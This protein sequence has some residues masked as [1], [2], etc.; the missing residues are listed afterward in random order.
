MLGEGFHVH[1]CN[2]AALHGPAAALQTTLA[3]G[4]PVIRDDERRVNAH[5]HAETGTL[6]AGAGGIVERKHTRRKLFHA[7]AV[8]RAGIIL[9]EED[10]LPV[11]DADDDQTVGQ[12]GG[13]LD[14]IRE[15]G[16]DVRTDDQTVDDD[17]DIMLLVFFELEFFGQIID[18]AIHA[19][20]DKATLARSIKLL[21]VLALA[22]AHDRCQHL[23]AAALRQRQNLI[24]DLVHGLLADLPAAD[25]AVRHTD[26][27]V[28]Q[29]EIVIDLRHGT[30]RGTRIL[31]SGFLID[32]D[33]RGKAVDVVHVR[34]FHLAEK[35]AGIAGKR[36]HI[37]PLAFRIDRIEGQGGFAGTGQTGQHDQL[38]ARQ[39][40][41]D[42]F[43]IVFPCTGNDDIL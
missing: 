30:H 21:L 11:H 42:I 34:L 10:I 28:H 19:H 43:Q 24:H 14:G 13:G 35:H 38:V 12:A 27:R 8:L 17:L 41:I 6:G 9:R 25:R 39:F 16:T 18:D 3:D 23:N 22:A 33:R 15:A 7:D 37:A 31:G 40:H 32:G 4:K 5:E 26:A 36:L 29:T 1:R 2:G 20:A